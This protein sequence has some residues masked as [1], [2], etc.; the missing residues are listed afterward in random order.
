MIRTIKA[1]SLAVNRG[2]WAM[3]ERI[4]QAYAAEKADL[5]RRVADR[6]APGGRF[7]LADVV[8]PERPEDAVIPCTPGFDLPDTVADQLEWLR[9]AGLDPRVTWSRRDLAVIEASLAMPSSGGAG[10]ARASV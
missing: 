5:F 1:C 7:V 9:A 2:K 8:V 4:T 6:L 3:L 10:F